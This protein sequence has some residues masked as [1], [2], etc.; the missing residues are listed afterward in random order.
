MSHVIAERAV[1]STLSPN[2]TVPAYSDDL[3]WVTA[4]L[5]AHMM[6][7]N[8]RRYAYILWICVGLIFLIGCLLHWTKFRGGYLGAMWSKWGIRRRTLRF[9]VNSSTPGHPVSL[10]SNGQL[11]CLATLSVVVLLLSFL[12][13][14][15]ISPTVGVFDLSSSGL[16]ARDTAYDVSWFVQ[17]Q[18]Q[19]TINKNWWTAGG[20]TGIIAFAL[21]PLCILFVLKAPPFALFALPFTVQIHF[22]KL[23]WLHR[24]SARLIWFI[25]TLHVTL[26][27]VQLALDRRPSTG[28]PGY[29]YAWQY[30]KFIFGW[31]AFALMTLLVF[32]SSRSLRKSHYE[33]FY[34]FHVVLVPLTLVMSAFHHPPLWIWCWIALGLWVGERAW[35][36]TWWLQVNGFF[37]IEK[38]ASAVVLPSRANHVPP[39]PSALQKSTFP[40]PSPYLDSRFMGS[41]DGSLLAPATG[42]TYSPP[43]G[44]ARAELLSGATVRLTYISPGY[45]SWAPGQHFLINIPSVSRFVT[46]PFTTASI[47][48]EQSP[49]TAGRAIIFLVRSKKG[50]TRDLWDHVAKLISTGQNHA[51]GEK[52]PNGTVMPSSGVLLKTYVE[53]P[54]GSVVR[55]KWESYSTTV[56]FVAGSGISFGLSVLEYV[57][58]CLAGRSGKHLGGRTGGWG[59]QDFM[60]RRVRFVWLIREYAHIHWCAS[61]IRRCMSMITSPGLE[62]DIF[63]T[64]SMTTVRRPI[65]SPPA[66]D[67]L[68]SPPSRTFA[69]SP[70]SDD[71]SESEFSEDGFV[72]LSYYAG[73]YGDEERDVSELPESER[74]NY[75]LDLTNWEDD[76]DASLPGED[77]LN[78]RI[79][80]EGKK[81]RRMTRMSMALDP[82]HHHEQDFKSRDS[83]RASQAST[84]ALLPYLE[85]S[86]R[87]SLD[88][89]RASSSDA[90]LL[91]PRSSVTPTLT[92][93]H[94]PTNSVHFSRPPTYISHS[95]YHPSPLHDRGPEMKLT[96]DTSPSF[97]NDHKGKGAISAVSETSFV[98][99]RRSVNPLLHVASP[100][101]RDVSA[102]SEKVRPGKPKLDRILHDEV[103]RAR[104]PIVVACCG[105][106]SFSAL[107]RKAVA[108]EI[109]PER[110]RKGDLRGIIDIVS[111]DFEF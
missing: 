97:P 83:V 98:P 75:I 102:V 67:N 31:I 12:G 101:M 38:S 55:T 26:W 46:H 10:P 73:E 107:V 94:S 70:I 88:S 68:L 51:P 29:T 49:L 39:T 82:K 25:T 44:Y 65:R 2:P 78:S 19:Y 64:K 18:P 79:H 8:S 28:K 47:C 104:G 71:D 42:I 111:E 36:A 81:L 100:E 57:C 86:S 99:D 1:T 20:R 61:I 45:T 32:S 59:T 16:S 13:P 53:G 108:G 6:S 22:D 24:W 76:N 52:P 66:D 9:R 21:L 96:I 90:H 54:F 4:Y 84:D 40:P 77:Q 58:L 85:E 23:S 41:P 14:D 35:R 72:D 91:T 15:Y 109:N 69:K 33:T 48:D 34:A 37:G 89:K 5:V 43:P 87:S 80:I 60:T 63:V 17:F 62:V 95:P 3:Q 105:P 11:L 92:Y 106:A 110:A 56:I 50:W 93:E 103:E 7:D 74:E 30:Q 27:S